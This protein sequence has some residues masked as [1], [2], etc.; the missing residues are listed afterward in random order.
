MIM[1]YEHYVVV[2]W[3]WER[4][5]LPSNNP[6]L[7]LSKSAKKKKNSA[8]RTLVISLLYKNLIVIIALINGYRDIL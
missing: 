3:H 6:L 5:K 7:F 8:L 2:G 1:V 4:L